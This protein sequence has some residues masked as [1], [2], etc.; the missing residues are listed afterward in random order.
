MADRKHQKPKDSV[1]SLFEAG[2]APPPDFGPSYYMSEPEAQSVASQLVEELR[3]LN[4]QFNFFLPIATDQH[5]TLSHRMMNRE[6]IRISRLPDKLRA[7][8]TVTASRVNGQLLSPG[9]ESDHKRVIKYWRTK[10]RMRALTKIADRIFEQCGEVSASGLIFTIDVNPTKAVLLPFL[11]ITAMDVDFIKTRVKSGKKLRTKLKKKLNH[12]PYWYL[13]LPENFNLVDAL[14]GELQ[15]V[16]EEVQKAF[17]TLFGFPELKVFRFGLRAEICYYEIAQDWMIPAPE[18]AFWQLLPRWLAPG[19]FP[20]D[21]YSNRAYRTTTVYDA[22]DPA[23]TVVRVFSICRVPRKD[24]LSRAGIIREEIRVTPNRKDFAPSLIPA[25]EQF[26]LYSASPT[27]VDGGVPALPI[28]F[29]ENSI[30]SIL[31]GFGSKAKFADFLLANEKAQVSLKAP[32]SGK[33]AQARHQVKRMMFEQLANA[34][35]V[36]PFGPSRSLLQ[37]RTS[38]KGARK[39]KATR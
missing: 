13:N 22:V 35:N 27:V 30:L 39:N 18:I 21:H 31:R 6:P 14:E 10:K 7:K 1:D 28:T 33:L 36:L 12:Y 15:N 17:A 2:E 23:E 19:R 4:R 25:F 26:D 11:D 3:S 24:R 16:V 29:L 9:S 38:P 32:G 37:F 8:I 34:F 20:L 5:D